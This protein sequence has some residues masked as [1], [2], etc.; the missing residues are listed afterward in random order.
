M[1]DQFIARL[2]Y[3]SQLWSKG[4]FAKWIGGA[5][6]LVG[7]MTFI[8]DD[9]FKADWKVVSVIPHLSWWEW[10]SIAGLIVVAWIFESSFLIVEAHVRREGELK[11]KL[12]TSLRITYQPGPYIDL[13]SGRDTRLVAYVSIENIGLV[14]QTNCRVRLRS[15]R[16][17]LPES[18]SAKLH[19]WQDCC[20]PFDLIL[21]DRK[22]VPVL[23]L[24]R[25]FGNE[26]PDFLST[27]SV[28]QRMGSWAECTTT[29][30]LVKEETYD[31]WVEALS[32][33]SRR[34]VITL[35]VWFDGSSWQI[36]TADDEQSAFSLASTGLGRPSAPAAG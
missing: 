12:S 20:A 27:M 26:A 28:D 3:L 10:A 15:H 25:P 8:R 7:V 18:P 9:I 11:D 6:S 36:K 4:L 2:R 17:G 1:A 35:R 14:S 29:L 33:E 21:D 22:L 23:Y 31:V 24:E 19:A 5:W 30:I 32:S 13:T 16:I 34:S